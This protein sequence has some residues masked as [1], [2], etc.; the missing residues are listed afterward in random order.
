MRG[1]TYDSDGQTYCRECHCWVDGNGCCQLGCE[2]DP[3]FN[4]HPVDALM[5]RDGDPLLATGTRSMWI[6]LF[7]R[8]MEKLRTELDRFKRREPQVR[9]LIARM[10]Q[11]AEPADIY[12]A[13]DRI[14]D[15]SHVVVNETVTVDETGWPLAWSLNP[16]AA[17]PV[18]ADKQCEHEWISI[19]RT[20]PKRIAAK[21]APSAPVDGDGG[22]R[23][24][25]DEA[26]AVAGKVGSELVPVGWALALH[27]LAAEVRRLRESLAD[28]SARHA[29]VHDEADKYQLRA[30]D[31]ERELSRLR[32][33]RV[34]DAPA[35]K[36]VHAH[37][38]AEAARQPTH[39]TGLIYA[40]QRLEEYIAGDSLEGT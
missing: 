11:G 21:P 1:K 28:V 12:D 26:L 4:E 27:R 31:A 13:A 15:R 34:R 7:D 23:M 14:R 3:R 18:N 9:E 29:R 20:L 32:A 6:G 10:I 39:S 35:L 37:L 16:P 22:T 2:A 5:G 36:A 33:E 8:E 17:N 24:T 30:L 38:V 40:A 25:V 19:E